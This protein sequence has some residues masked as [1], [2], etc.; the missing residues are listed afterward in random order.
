MTN[1]EKAREAGATH[2]FINANGATLYG[3]PQSAKTMLVLCADLSTWMPE[4][5]CAHGHWLPLS[6]RRE[7]L[8]IIDAISARYVRTSER[9]RKRYQIGDSLTVSVRNTPTRYAALAEMAWRR[10]QDAYPC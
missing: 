9:L 2:K 1:D 6:S 10:F 4:P 7:R 3:K 5:V 8:Q